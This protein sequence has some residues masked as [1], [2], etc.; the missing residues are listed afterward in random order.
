MLKLG[1][2]NDQ[3]LYSLGKRRR[4]PNGHSRVSGN[5]EAPKTMSAFARRNVPTKE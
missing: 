1:Q 3:S 2:L 4:Q 5:L